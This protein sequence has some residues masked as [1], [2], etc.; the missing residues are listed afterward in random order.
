MWYYCFNERASTENK[1]IGI[2]DSIC[3]NLDR[4]FYQTPKY[5]MKN[6]GEI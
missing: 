4:Q 3:E 1:F 2:N 5:H 6:L